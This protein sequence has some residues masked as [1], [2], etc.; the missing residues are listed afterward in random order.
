MDVFL[1]NCRYLIQYKINAKYGLTFTMYN[2]IL[3]SG[4]IVES[5]ISPLIKRGLPVK[6]FV[7]I[8]GNARNAYLDLLLVDP[9]NKKSWHPDP[10]SWDSGND[11]G[12]LNLKE[13]EEYSTE[14]KFTIPIDRRVGEYKALIV[15]SEVETLDR[16]RVKELGE[17]EG[18][19]E[20]NKRVHDFQEISFTVTT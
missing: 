18:I 6:I 3:E 14:W 5:K 13:H 17:I 1:F 16:D 2:M 20:K 15:L 12:I 4:S 7:K 19:A 9:D 10:S 11:T 8:M